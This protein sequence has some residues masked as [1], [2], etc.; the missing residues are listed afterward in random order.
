[1]YIKI[2]YIIIGVLFLG[3]I[4]LFIRGDKAEPGTILATIAA[5]IATIKSKLFG[6]SGFKEKAE[7]IRNA[8]KTER[9]EWDKEKR[10]YELQYELLQMKM[11]SLDKKT[12]DLKEEFVRNSQ[13][14]NKA[15]QRTEDEILEWLNK[16]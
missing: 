11:D 15:S 3:I 16:H 7:I 14:G 6:S 12:E 4:A 9:E 8:H 2:K 13:S 1:M 5:F 10:N